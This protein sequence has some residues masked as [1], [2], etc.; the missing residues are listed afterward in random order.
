M[1][2]LR[3]RIEEIRGRL[4]AVAVA[5]AAVRGLFWAAGAFCVLLVAHRLV[6]LDVS[7][8]LLGAVCLIAAGA[9]ALAAGALRRAGALEAALVADAQARLKERLTSALTVVSPATDVER[10]LVADARARAEKLRAADAVP[11]VPPREIRWLPAPLLIALLAALLLPSMDLLGRRARAREAA[12]TT[13]LLREQAKK[14]EVKK[15]DLLERAKVQ[16]LTEAPKAAQ[17]MQKLA[18][19]MKTGAPDKKEA[20]ARISKLADDLDRKQEQ[21]KDRQETGRRIMDALAKNAPKEETRL[22][23]LTREGKFDQAAQELERLRD[24][25][26]KGDL[27]VDQREKLKQALDR[28]RDRMAEQL[29]KSESGGRELKALSDMAKGLGEA[30][31]D[32][33]GEDPRKA[34]EALKDLAREMQGLGQDLGELEAMRDLLRDLDDMKDGLAQRDE[35]CEGEPGKG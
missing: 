32:L 35:P 12:A 18:E 21:Y 5:R 1:D 8:P 9:A 26:A 11:F 16:K 20:M 15:Q 2:I 14:L 27:P 7:L 34:A 30:A 29:D 13:A 31:R 10:A 28:M 3:R 24:Q 22:E 33:L 6:D 25:L 19:L 17:E 4:R 23:R